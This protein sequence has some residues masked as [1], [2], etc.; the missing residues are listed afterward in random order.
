[1]ALFVSVLLD[2]ALHVSEGAVHA[3]GEALLH[4][5]VV[6]LHLQ[7]QRQVCASE[8]L[9]FQEAP[10]FSIKSWIYMDLKK[11]RKK[12][13]KVDF[14]VLITVEMTLISPQT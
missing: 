5:P 6:L 10:S 2:A 11:K 8:H 12:K 13:N 1:M 14:Q 4:L 7:G 9:C 3:L